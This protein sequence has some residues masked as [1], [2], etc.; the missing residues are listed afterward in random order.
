M[1]PKWALLDDPFHPGSKT[2]E[3][4]GYVDYIVEYVGNN[5]PL[6]DPILR[7]D[8]PG[9]GFQWMQY[10]ARPRVSPAIEG[11]NWRIGLYGRDYRG[12]SLMPMLHAMSFYNFVQNVEC[13]EF[14]NV[15][16]PTARS[17]AYVYERDGR[18]RAYLF[19]NEPAP[20]TTLALHSEVPYR[21][22][23]LYGREDQVTPDGASLV[24]ATLDPLALIFDGQVPELYDSKTAKKALTPVEGGVDLPVVARG[25]SGTATVTLP[26]VFQNADEIRVEATVDGTWPQID[27]VQLSPENQQGVEARMPVA[28]AMDRRPGSYTF[29]TRITRGETTISVLKQPLEVSELLSATMRGVPMTRSQDPAVA[30]IVRSLADKPMTGTIRLENRFFGREFTPAE[31]EA[32]YEVPARGE[33]KVRFPVP[34][35]QANLSSSYVL[36]AQL[37]DDTGFSIRTEDEVSFQASV[38]TDTPITVDG[39]LSDWNLDR[40]LPIPF[41]RWMRGP[42]EPD[43]FSGHFYSR[44]DEE[45]LYFA[46]VITDNVPVVTGE[47]QVSWNDDNIMFG[48]YPWRWHMGEPLNTGYYR[49]HL[50]PIKGGDAS[51]MRVGYVPS[52]PYTAEGAEIAVERTDNG[53]IYEWSYPA[54]SLYPLELE[55]GSGF[56]LSMSVWDQHQVEKKGWGKFTWLTFSGFNTSVNAQ[57][58]L[59]RQFTFVK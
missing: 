53:W 55:P 42:R 3:I 10:V 45:R 43:E 39:D 52:G 16:R 1:A 12:S 2:F 24:V 33:T 7:G 23:D 46:A 31:M 21:M 4:N 36:S 27:P 37:Q 13:A 11:D 14:K 57:P 32:R 44:W 5:G 40:L 38:H 19:L 34:R 6:Q 35:E 9:D 29:T 48:I 58:D 51:F 41:E 26:P 18:T 47:D 28:V 49:E 17:V 54:E 8:F 22:Q 59:W 20:A 25:A 30:V 56:R 15:F 50:G